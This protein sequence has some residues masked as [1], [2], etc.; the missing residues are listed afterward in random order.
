MTCIPRC[1]ELPG[2]CSLIAKGL[3]HAGV[4][5]PQPMLASYAGCQ[6]FHWL[7]QCP[8]VC[9]VIMLAMLIH[10]EWVSNCLT[11]LLP[12]QPRWINACHQS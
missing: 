2:I 9:K 7:I 6:H 5:S 11:F 3:G 1:S 10:W 4:Y 12:Q 8:N